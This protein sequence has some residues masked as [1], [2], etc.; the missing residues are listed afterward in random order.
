MSS[1]STPSFSILPARTP[2]D[3]T[4][5]TTLITAY[6]T[7]LNLDLS[8]QNLSNEL[9]QFPGAYTPPTGELLLAR[10]TQTGEALGCVALRALPRSDAYGQESRKVDRCCEM[11]RL[12]VPPR[13][14]GKGVGVA[15]VIAVIEVAEKMGYAE[16]KLDTLAEMQVARRMY[17]RLG[18]VEV[19]P[20]YQNPIEGAIYLGKRLGPTSG[21]KPKLDVG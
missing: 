17:K 5:C 8:F 7:S 16:M 11:K 14:R 21:R 19:E 9:S 4:A 20:Y 1:T 3:I 18:F 6:T 15:L 13:G 10:D 12:Y 2:S